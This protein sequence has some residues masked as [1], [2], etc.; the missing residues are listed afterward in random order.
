[1]TKRRAVLSGIG[2]F[3]AARLLGAQSV[4]EAVDKIVRELNEKDRAAKESRV[5]VEK[6]AGLAV[7][8]DDR[9]L[10]FV[11][12]SLLGAIRLRKVEEIAEKLDPKWR[13]KA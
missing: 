3:F 7:Q 4:S 13:E 8:G 2:S 6:A 1:M 11:L 10:R 5:L 12:V 9:A